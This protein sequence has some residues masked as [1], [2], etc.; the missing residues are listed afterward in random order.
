[1]ESALLEHPAVSESAVVSHPHSLK[2][3]CL[4]CF[5]TLRVGYEFTKSLEDELKKQGTTSQAWGGAE[6]VLQGLGVWGMQR[7]QV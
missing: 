5:V 1:M 4:Y 2:G 7:G 6:W 3:E